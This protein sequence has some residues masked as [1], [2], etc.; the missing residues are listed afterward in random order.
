MYNSTVSG[1]L[2]SSELPQHAELTLLAVVGIHCR[3]RQEALESAATCARAGINAVLVTAG[4]IGTAKAIA[5]KC[6]LHAED[7]W[8]AAVSARQL[9]DLRAQDESAFFDFLPRIR[10]LANASSADR[11]AFIDAL[12]ELGE[13]V[14]CTAAAPEEAAALLVADVGVAVGSATAVA[15]D[16]A[17]IAVRS[18]SFAA[19]IKP[20]AW[21]RTVNTN[22]R[23]FLQYQLSINVAVVGLTI[24]GTLS[25][26]TT[27]AP[28][29]PVQLL[30]INLVMDTLGAAALASER[31]DADVLH[32]DPVYQEA[33]L[34][35]NKMTA[36]IVSNGLFQ[37][38]IIFLHMFSSHTWL[39]TFAG[40]AALCN[41]A[42]NLRNSTAWSECHWTCVKQ[43]GTF[44]ADRWC[45]Q[46]A[47][48]STIVFNIFIWMQIFSMFNARFLFGGI[49][50]FSSLRKSFRL[51]LVAFVIVG[52][53]IFAV[54]VAGSF[55][56]TTSLSWRHWLV[57]V[58]FG[59][60]ILPLSLVV[61]LIDI[62]DETP[63]EAVFK[64]EHRKRMHRLQYLFTK[65]F[66][67]RSSDGKHNLKKKI[68]QTFG[69]ASE[70]LADRR[71]KITI[72]A[73]P[74]VS[75]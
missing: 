42:G 65:A 30:W 51:C 44:V 49:N 48:H 64:E 68:L 53:Q 47:S 12:H 73:P 11:V 15:K 6:G 7:G 19:V 29:T 61:R 56:Q 17:D 22:V 23:K 58:A 45:Q 74:S 16:A 52:F 14:A 72:F 63:I 67:R 33:D 25:S 10:V 41:V 66:A 69:N 5:T 3:V 37:A 46:G 70:P 62:P 20:I 24:F 38:G 54:E 71:R 50:P 59:A 9:F 43:G 34:I 28:F 26:N 40:P 2:N 27:K 36:F 1:H 8:S 21:G 75:T 57:C 35:S 4:G 60:S 32:R 55:M 39:E 18:D 13:V 31:P